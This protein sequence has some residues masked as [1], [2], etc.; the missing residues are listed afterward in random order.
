MPALNVMVGGSA[1]TLFL[2]HSLPDF[3]KGA[4][5]HRHVFS[6][7]TIYHITQARSGAHLALSFRDLADA[8]LQPILSILKGDLSCISPAAACP[9]SSPNSA[10]ARSVAHHMWRREHFGEARL[11]SL[12]LTG[13]RITDAGVKLLADNAALSTVRFIDLKLNPCSSMPLAVRERAWTD[14]AAKHLPRLAAAAASPA[15]REQQ[16][17]RSPGIVSSRPARAAAAAV[18]QKR[19]NA[20]SNMRFTSGGTSSSRSVSH[21]PQQSASSRT[22]SKRFKCNAVYPE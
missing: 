18:C 6:S 2:D 17:A 4:A 10:A 1:A 11:A 15:L 22:F 20:A 19:D 16:A 5:L 9:P 8:D 13:N 12:D 3:S 14:A 7:N 21:Q